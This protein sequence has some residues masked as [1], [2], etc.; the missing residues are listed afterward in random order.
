MSFRYTVLYLSIYRMHCQRRTLSVL[1][2]LNLITW[3]SLLLSIKEAR[4]INLQFSQFIGKN[5]G[6]RGCISLPDA[7][8][9]ELN[10]SCRIL[11]GA[12]V[13][14]MFLYGAPVWGDSLSVQSIS[15]VHHHSVPW[16]PWASGL[17]RISKKDW[18]CSFYLFIF[19]LHV[20]YLSNRLSGQK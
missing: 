13:W 8:P 6:H 11:Y 17:I 7:K 14:L 1:S 2:A 19:F 12:D 3:V 16:L 5:C 9:K 20:R 15:A 18:T 10:T 4:L